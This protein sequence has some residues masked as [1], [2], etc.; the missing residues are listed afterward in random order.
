MYQ[1]LYYVFV[2]LAVIAILWD[3]IAYFERTASN[4]FTQREYARLWFTLILVA[5]L[6]WGAFINLPFVESPKSGLFLLFGLLGT[7]IIAAEIIKEFG[8][9]YMRL[10]SVI[11]SP[12][13]IRYWP[14]WVIRDKEMVVGKTTVIEFGL[15]ESV[16]DLNLVLISESKSSQPALQP[17]HA[18]KKISLQELP[19]HK[20]EEI[21]KSQTIIYPL[22]KYDEKAI[23]ESGYFSNQEVVVTI[24]CEAPSF[25]PKQQQ[26]KSDIKGLVQGSVTFPLVPLNH[27][28]QQFVFK[29]LDSEGLVKGSIKVSANVVVSKSK[30]VELAPKLALVVTTLLGFISTILLIV[31][32]G[33]ELLK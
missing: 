1:N 8:N 3:L 4:L 12:F 9:K 5:F 15:H 10:G 20:K 22:Q 31:E 33:R 18:S 19:P 17:N 28:K 25:E 32:K 21:L 13:L 26:I 14:S 23:T 6:L 11:S 24:V 30:I 16:F 27:G 7:A 2:I 29:L